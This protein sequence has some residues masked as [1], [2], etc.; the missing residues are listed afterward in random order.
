[1]SD[2]MPNVAITVRV[3]ES[4][5]DQTAR[6]SALKA[7][8]SQ[9]V[10][11][12]LE[13]YLGQEPQARPAYELARRLGYRVCSSARENSNQRPVIHKN[14]LI[15]TSESFERFGMVLSPWAPVEHTR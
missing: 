3:P 8:E 9:L 14:R 4:P 5:R 12:A 10:R 15:A 6:T 7:V 2:S 13:T 1:M 11:E